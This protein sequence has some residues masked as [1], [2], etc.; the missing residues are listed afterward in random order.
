M[1]ITS[2]LIFVG[3]TTAGADWGSVVGFLRF[4]S[5]SKLEEVAAAV[6]GASGDGVGLA[7]PEEAAAVKSAFDFEFCIVL[8]FAGAGAV[9]AVFGLTGWACGLLEDGACGVSLVL[10]TKSDDE[11]ETTKRKKERKIKFKIR[12]YSWEKN[13]SIYNNIFSFNRE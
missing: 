13:Y 4:L 8:L 9:A 7:T 5:V 12:N 3:A 11:N 2:S 1:L 6:D 10:L